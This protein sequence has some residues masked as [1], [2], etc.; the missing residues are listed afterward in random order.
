MPCRAASRPTTNRPIR[1]DT[2]DVHDGRVVQPP[3]GVRPSPR[4][5]ADAAV[6]DRRAARRRWSAAARTRAPGSPAGENEVAFST[7][8]ATRCTTSLTAWP[9]TRDAGL[10]VAAR[11]ART[12]R[13]RTPPPA[14]RRPAGPAGSTAARPRGP[15]R[16]SRFSQLRRMRVARWS[17]RNRLPSRSASCSP[18]SR[19]SISE[20]C[21]STRDWLRRDRLTNIALTLPRSSGLVGR[22]PDRLAVNLVE[23]PRDFTDLVGG[24]H[25]DRLDLDALVRALGLTEAAHHVRQPGTGDVERVLPQPAQRPDHRAGDERGHQQDQDQQDQRDDADD[26]RGPGG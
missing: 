5:H 8:S 22:Q 18:C 4:R 12:A 16:T 13:P 26:D 24:G 20:I 7:S 10:D 19:S 17:S 3:V 6:G 14:A 9:T 11:P 21:R 15:P 23:G 2:A 1:R 25:P